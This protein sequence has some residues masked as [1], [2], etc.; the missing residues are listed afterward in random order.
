MFDISVSAANA[1]VLGS[2]TADDFATSIGDTLSAAASSGVLAS[3][4][5]S[6]AGSSSALVTVAVAAVTTFVATPT[7][8]P[9]PTST[10]VSGGGGSNPKDDD[11]EALE[12]GLGLGLGLPLC[13]MAAGAI[14]YWLHLQQG[15]LPG[16]KSP[17]RSSPGESA[18]LVV[19]PGAVELGDTYG[20]LD[21]GKDGEENCFDPEEPSLVVTGQMIETNCWAEA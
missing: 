11:S 9:S 8:T 20:P 6:A 19:N 18:E 2:S 4:I 17:L 14:A 21:D 5:A 7:P 10:L 3:N 1:R 13:L 16:P 15:N 12:L